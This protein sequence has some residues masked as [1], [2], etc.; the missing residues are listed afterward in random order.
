M[1]RRRLRIG[2]LLLVF[3]GSSA[4]AGAARGAGDDWSQQCGTGFRIPARPAPDPVEPGGGPGAID[5][6]ADEGEFIEDGVSTFT[7]N[8]R[9]RRG[10]QQLRSDEL[11]YDGGTLE[12]GGKVGFWD[13][14]I[15]VASERARA[16]A[17][18]DVVTLESGLSYMLDDVHGHGGAHRL[19][20]FGNARTTVD[21]A[22]YTTCNPGDADW[23]VTARNV[24]FDHVEDTGTARDV[25]LEFMGQRVFYMPWLSFPLSDRRKSG[26]LVPTYGMGGSR[27]VALTI[28]YYFNLAPNRDATLTT[29]VMSERGVQALGEFRF[30]SRTYGAGRF[31][32]H[33]LPSDA[34]FGDDRAAFDFAHR[35]RWSSRWSTDARFEWASDAEYFGD[36]GAGLAQS[37]RTHL[38][39][40]FDARYDGDGW[41]ARFRLRDHLTLD[42]TILPQDRPYASLPQILVRTKL[43]ERNRA[44]N[45]GARAE[46]T[47]FDQRGRTTGARM[48]L[49][50]SVTWP[51]RT[52]GTFVVPKAALHFTRY[53]LD[54]TGTEASMKNDPSRLVPSFSLDSGVF[55]ERPATFHGRSLTH[56]IEPRL[57]YLYVPF[58][59]QDDL[60]IF[61]TGR[62][63]FNFAQLFREDR[64]SGRDRI[65]DANQVALAL[66]SRILDERGGELARASVGQ[67]RYFRDRKVALDDTDAAETARSSD[68]VAGVEAR[69]SRKWRVRA[70][71][72]YDT[73]ADRTARNTFGVR[74][75]PD[76][77][78][79][80]NAA[81]RLVDDVDQAEVSFAWP[82][83]ARWRTVGRWNFAFNEERNKTLEAFGGL[84]YESCCWGLRVVAR[85]FLL[86]NSGGGD[87]Y[88]NG[89][90]LQLELKGLTG[91]GHR[92]DAF[93]ERSIPGY[94]NEF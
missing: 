57:Y 11:T 67:I 66:T 54:R 14:G 15:Y 53:A 76:E 69:P 32:A 90:F 65:G 3:A 2:C 87:G 6:S 79:V 68:V 85:R 60:P 35:H 30:L 41:R 55:L 80:L 52:S 46:L 82:I 17:G 50:P 39:R 47:Y 29:R 48:D 42:R 72:R 75:R 88:S 45:F 7:G 26:F 12:A 78:R 84:E 93:L 38:P 64:F 43:P 22:T 81:Y 44:L 71:L 77:R 36:L 37:S 83:G 51:F 92:A 70:S 40:R 89:I 4:F 8:V 25:W 13:E 5:L 58:R 10:S 9:I 59:S 34:E 20:R 62:F 18:T 74:Y 33:Y 56:T 23:R 73:G 49:Q 16:E 31:E 61:D 91:V 19:T 21:G 24:E 28:H 86:G 27:W 94:E 63:S 1:N